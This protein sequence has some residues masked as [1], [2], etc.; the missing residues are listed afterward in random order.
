[1]EDAEL[2]AQ[3]FTSPN[4][5]DIFPW[6]VT[7]HEPSGRQITLS[8]DVQWRDYAASSPEIVDHSTQ[9]PRIEGSAVFTRPCIARA[10]LAKAMRENGIRTIAE[11]DDNYFCDPSLN[12][13]L[14]TQGEVELATDQHAKAMASMDANIFSTR[15]LRD[16]YHKEYRA[17]FGK[18]VR[19]EMHV[20]RNHIARD[21]WPTRIEG[22]GKVRVGFMGSTSHVW[23]INLAYPAFHAAHEMGAKTWMIGYSPSDPQ[24]DVMDT[25]TD[26]DGNTVDLR[27]VKGREAIRKWGLIVDRHQRWIAPDEYHRAALPLDIGIAPLMV[28]DF[29]LGKSDVKLLEHTISGAASI[30][31]NHPIYNT[32]GWVHEKNCLMAGSPRELAEATIRLIRNP[33][34]R[35]DLVAAA[36]DYVFNERSEVQM[37]K[38]WEAA[39]VSH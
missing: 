8:T 25:F 22:D 23:D 19:P 12:L 39:V 14:R 17:R 16:R 36:Q 32:S 10:T 11:T 35:S 7:M 30:C 37:K 24:P 31:S 34:L 5:S 13:F 4:E 2:A 33:S 3:V 38:E 27:S 26:Q 28:N 1:M 9:F 20:C 29:T 15:W 6:S 21:Q 18:Q